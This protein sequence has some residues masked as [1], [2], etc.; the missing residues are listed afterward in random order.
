MLRPLIN[1][2]EDPGSAF[3][4]AGAKQFRASCSALYIAKYDG[5]QPAP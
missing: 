2:Q 5:P 1:P 3:T 4:R